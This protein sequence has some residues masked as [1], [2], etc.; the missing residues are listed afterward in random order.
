MEIVD[1]Y[2]Y[3]YIFAGHKVYVG[4]YRYTTPTTTYFQIQIESCSG[5]IYKSLCVTFFSMCFVLYVFVVYIILKRIRPVW[6]E[7]KNKS[8]VIN[9]ISVF[10][11]IIIIIIIQAKEEGH[12]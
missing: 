1:I 5:C 4:E 11:F 9:C 10:F 6:E 12:G 8:M 7:K 3:G 2:L